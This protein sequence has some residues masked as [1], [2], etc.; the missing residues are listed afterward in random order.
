M[1][2]KTEIARNRNT[3]MLLRTMELVPQQLLNL[4]MERINGKREPET[5]FS[6]PSLSICLFKISVHVKL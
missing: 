3:N 1:I 6:L 5:A 2:P 4:L